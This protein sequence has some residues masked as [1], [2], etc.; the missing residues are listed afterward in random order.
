[1][2]KIM[3]IIL[4]SVAQYAIAQESLTGRN[5]HDPLFASKGKFNAGV[6]A[7]Y[8]DKTPPP[9]MIFD[10]TYGVT[11]KFSAGLVVGTTGVLALYGIKLN[12]VLYQSQSNFRTTFRFTSVYYQGR[13][14]KFL[15]DRRD[16]KVMPWIL[17]MA[18][19]DAEWKT[20]KG[21]RYSIGMGLLETH[22]VDGMM[23][24]IRGTKPDAEEKEEESPFELF[25]TIQGSVSIPISK[26][27]MIRPEVI[28]IMKGS[29]LIETGEYKVAFPINPYLNLV[30]TF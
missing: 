18:V 19:A 14:G 15:F 28:A 8:T 21:I 25:N 16:K 30:Y 20:K 10:A 27:L 12:K 11:R 13:D 7:T 4:I 24:L 17:S 6:I 3:T 2:K 26:K 9:A 1:M 22:C 29:H 23:N 5:Q